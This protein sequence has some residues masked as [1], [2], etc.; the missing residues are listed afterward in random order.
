MAKVSFS[1][2]KDEQGRTVR[3]HKA[4]GL[5]VVTTKTDIG[6]EFVFYAPRRDGK[7]A[8]G[9][10]GE[11][12]TMQEMRDL[13]EG[14]V[15]ELLTDMEIAHEEAVAEDADHALDA[16]AT[17]VV[18]EPE[19]LWRRQFPSVAAMVDEK[20]RTDAAIAE[21]TAPAL[22]RVE[23]IEFGGA[24][25]SS[26]VYML[27]ARPGHAVCLPSMPKMEIVKRGR[28]WVVAIAGQRLAARRTKRDAR[29]R[30]D[31]WLV[32]RLA[33]IDPPRAAAPAPKPRPACPPVKLRHGMIIHFARN[34]EARPTLPEGVTGAV[35]RYD[36]RDA[37]ETAPGG[38]TYTLVHTSYDHPTKGRCTTVARVWLDEIRTTG[39][40]PFRGAALV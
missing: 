7:E 25:M 22:D 23:L 20:E 18:T 2:S 16:A 11:A 9:Y 4:T 15:D 38:R 40:N 8:L 35:W 13:A 36:G 19:P 12:R 14:K 28:E 37:I 30:L 29:V 5:R 1:I 26:Y 3:T 33:E 31:E 27:S 6:T 34:A 10:W 39:G 21:A 24:E 17:V 32:A